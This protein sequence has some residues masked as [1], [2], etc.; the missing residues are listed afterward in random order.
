MK[1]VLLAGAEQ[2]LKDLRTYL[3]KN[4]GVQFWESSYQQI[5][6]TIRSLS[7]FPQ[8]GTVPDEISDLK[9]GQYRQVV[10]GMN[11]I[12]YEICGDTIHVHVICD[13]RRQ[14]RTILAR[15]MLRAY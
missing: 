5:K 2:D 4:F 11:R 12:I 7:D 15:R 8:V 9:L 10:S 1:V 3:V 13:T 6:S 14:L